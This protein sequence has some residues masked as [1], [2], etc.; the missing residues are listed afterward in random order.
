[1]FRGCAVGLGRK[2]VLLGGFPVRLVHLIPPVE[3]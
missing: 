1:M 3:V 2:S